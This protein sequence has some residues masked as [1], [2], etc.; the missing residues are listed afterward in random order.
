MATNTAGNCYLCGATMAKGAMKN[1]LIKVHG[2][3]ENGEECRVIKV[4]G[5]YEKG[6]W[7][8]IDVPLNETLDR[9]D[10]FLRMIWLECCGHM[11]QFC[12]APWQEEIPM[13]MKVKDLIH[14]EKFFHLYD[15]GT[16]TETLL[17]VV[18]AIRRPPQ[19]GGVRLLARNVPPVFACGK[20]GKDAKYLSRDM[21]EPFYCGDCGDKFDMDE[22]QQLPIV[23]SPR[24]GECAYCG[25]ADVFAFDPKAL[26]KKPE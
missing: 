7:L 11:S 10:H 23:N 19:K 12:Q 1:H 3:C 15:F 9:V 26:A 17:T 22:E 25:E 24:M 20:C 4:E 8:L 2:D 13:D 5:V 18:G 14:G 16:T 6:Y 21:D